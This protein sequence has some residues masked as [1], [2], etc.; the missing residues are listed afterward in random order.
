MVVIDIEH[1]LHWEIVNLVVGPNLSK[2]S[3]LFS[4]SMCF[5]MFVISMA[6]AVKMKYHFIKLVQNG[7]CND[8]WA[9]RCVQRQIFPRTICEWTSPSTALPGGIDVNVDFFY[10]SSCCLPSQHRGWVVLLSYIVFL[11]GLKAY[12]PICWS[13]DHQRGVIHQTPVFF[14]ILSHAYIFVHVNENIGAFKIM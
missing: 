7:V 11:V 9:T 4:F 5:I 2:R 6:R 10:N 1:V 12:I 8:I 3:L 14:V 13:H